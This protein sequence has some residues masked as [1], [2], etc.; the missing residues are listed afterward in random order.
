MSA[1][2]PSICV[3]LAVT[4]NTAFLELM[5]IPNLIRTYT[6]L[7]TYLPL[8]T[9]VV[10]ASPETA[11]GVHRLLDEMT[12]EYELIICQLLNP[13]SF[14]KALNPLLENS[15]SVLI[16][17]ASRPLTDKKE[18]ERVL[19]AFKDDIDAV[20]PAM[21][22]T[23]TLKILGTDSVIKE[24]LDR[25]T[26]LRIA[27]PELIRVSAVDFEGNDRGWFLPL[28]MGVRVMHTEG[29]PDGLRINSSEDRDL[30]EFF[31]P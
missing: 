8:Q 30:M 13:N 11:P 23:E 5:G 28:K 27:T 19:V 15:D 4:S 18:F 29:S 3:V 22:F 6:S 12:E 17:D 25:A 26:V 21:P 14:A 1:T 2:N 10:A 16:H 7:R 24:T 9:V 20:R 31:K